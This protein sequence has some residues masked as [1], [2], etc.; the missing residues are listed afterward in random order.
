MFGIPSRNPILKCKFTTDEDA[1][2]RQLVA[3]LGESNWEAVARCMPKRSVRQCRERWAHYLSPGVFDG[4]WSKAEDT[5]L[6]AKVLEVGRKW[7]LFELYFPGRTDVNIKNRY[8][9]LSR[10]MARKLRRRPMDQSQ[11]GHEAPTMTAFDVGDPDDAFSPAD[12]CWFD[13]F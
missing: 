6:K 3:E 12:V 4:Q 5:L 8:A 7:K 13:D 2:L 10:K 11:T 9:V 1:Q